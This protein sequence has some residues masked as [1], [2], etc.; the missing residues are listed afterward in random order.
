MAHALT[1]QHDFLREHRAVLAVSAL[2]HLTLLVLLAL[3]LNL[4]PRTPPQPVRL[5]IQATVVVDDRA[6]RQR[7][8]DAQ[9]RRQQAELAEQSRQER[10]AAQRE[11]EAR[12]LAA[13]QQRA[14][15]ER[16]A[17]V[18]AQQAEE[19][20]RK[21]DADARLRAQAR[22][23]A[24]AEAKARLDAAARADAEARVAAKAEA[25]ARARAQAERRRAQ[26]QADLARQMAEEEA[27]TAVAGSPAAAQYRDLI[28]QKVRRNW[29]EPASARPG[30]SCD[31]RVQQIPGGEVV[32]AVAFNCT[33]DGAFARSVEAAVLRSSPL[34][35]PADPRLFDRNLLFTFKPEQ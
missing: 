6:A 8:A 5:A 2:L 18:Q 9:R 13:E 35:L 27:L 3:N 4:L 28:A 7:A 23:K 26:S 29:N 32:S 16:Q 21:A 24:D 12:R 19:I 15:Q 30:D 33:G 11:A 1:F 31:V 20:R 14:A 22:A 17:Q 25:D 34:P 10:E